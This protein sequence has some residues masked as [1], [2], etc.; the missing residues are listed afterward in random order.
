MKGWK[1]AFAAA[2]VAAGLLLTG[3]GGDGGEEVSS[4]LTSENWIGQEAAVELLE[5]LTQEETG[6]SLP[7]QYYQFLPDEEVGN[8]G[9]TTCYIIHAYLTEDDTGKLHLEATLY[10]AV[11]GSQ[12]YRYDLNNDA[13][14]QVWGTEQ[15][16]TTES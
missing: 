2:L 9:E 14:T 12:V 10:V 16:E 11:D 4:S 5:G 8:I 13:F 3:C 6:L 15:Q 1:T 7:A